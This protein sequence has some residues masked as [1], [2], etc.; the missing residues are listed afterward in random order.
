MKKYNTFYIVIAI[1]FI[2]LLTINLFFFKGSRSFPG[3]TYSKKYM[4]NTERASI[5]GNTYV[6]PGQPVEPGDLLL[7]LSSP[8]LTLE[9]ET[10]KKEKYISKPVNSSNW[11]YIM[12]DRLIKNESI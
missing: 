7:E 11:R 4:V 9:I 5:A 3:V 6:I 10:L 1:L 12:I 2:T 8:E